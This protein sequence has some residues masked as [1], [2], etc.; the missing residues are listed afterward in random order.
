MYILRF[1]FAAITTSKWDLL[2][3]NE[4]QEQADDIDGQ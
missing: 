1:Y 2:E 3:Q 4:E